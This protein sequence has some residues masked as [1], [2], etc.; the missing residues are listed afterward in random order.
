MPVQ[1]APRRQAESQ[2]L[3]AATERL[4]DA[5]LFRHGAMLPSVQSPSKIARDSMVSVLGP[6]GQH[7]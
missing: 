5:Q 1:R 7:W 6:I 2:G 4:L 3:H